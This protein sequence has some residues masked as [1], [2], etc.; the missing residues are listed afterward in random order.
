MTRLK[1][2]LIF[3]VCLA[4]LG[5]AVPALE[6]TQNQ[7]NTKP[8]IHIQVKTYPAQA[9]PGQELWGGLAYLRQS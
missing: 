6:T 8:P 4:T 3:Y 2:F 1:L 7:L 5:T 9:S